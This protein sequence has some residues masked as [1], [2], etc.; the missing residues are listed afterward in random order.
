MKCEDGYITV[1]ADIYVENHVQEMIEA[2]GEPYLLQLMADE[3]IYEAAANRMPY[4]F[5]D[6]LSA[7]DKYLR[8]V[9][10]KNLDKLLVRIEQEIS[11]RKEQ[12]P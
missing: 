11:R 2:V 1:K 8:E 12:K 9:E 4:A 7:C 3:K 6:F 5:A 10:D